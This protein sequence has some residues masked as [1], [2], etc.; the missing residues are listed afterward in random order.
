MTAAMFTFALGAG[1]I[2]LMPSMT[3]NYLGAQES[4]FTALLSLF[5]GGIALGAVFTYK[6]ARRRGFRW[7][8]T[9]GCC[10]MSLSLAVMATALARWDLRGAEPWS[11]LELLS[12]TWPQCLF[13]GLFFLAFFSSFFVVPLYTLLVG[14]TPKEIRSQLI[15]ANNV[16]NSFFMV[17]SSAVI[18]LIFG[19]GLK[20]HHLLAAYAA[21]QL[22]PLRGLRQFGQ[23]ISPQKAA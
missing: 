23:A 7:C 8:L 5:C 6:L 18:I 16:L 22:I 11:F 19:W 15:G 12:F 14:T 17:L 4:V 3:T 21:L 20:M 1:L 13:I 9:A 2:V 10:G